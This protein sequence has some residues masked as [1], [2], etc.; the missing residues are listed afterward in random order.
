[1]AQQFGGVA[2]AAQQQLG[3]ISDS[4]RAVNQTAQ[5]INSTASK[6]GLTA[7]QVNTLLATNRSTLVGTLGNINQITADLRST[8]ATL[9]PVVNRVQQGELLQNLESLS[10]NAAQASAEFRD[11]S[12]ALNSP[13]N[14]ITLQQTLDSARATFQNV[15]KI[16]TDLDELTGD[17]KLR[18]SLRNL[19]QGLGKLVSSTQELQQ[20]AQLAELL[21]APEPVPPQAAPSQLAVPSPEPVSATRPDQSNP[22]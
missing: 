10:A 14:L 17:P 11:L 13:S 5:S 6:L 20:Q 16:T 2:Q 7:D 1:V 3:T 9:A 19:I 21:S 18:E 12:Q 22:L 4:T 15:Q 8:V